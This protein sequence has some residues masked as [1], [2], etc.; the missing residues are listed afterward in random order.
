[1]RD[2]RRLAAE[3]PT[4]SSMSIRTLQQKAPKGLMQ[5]R[6]RPNRGGQ[7]GRRAAAPLRFQ[8]AEEE[9]KNRNREKKHLWGFISWSCAV[10]SSC[11]HKQLAR[12]FCFPALLIIIFCSLQCLNHWL[13]FTQS[14]HTV[15]FLFFFCSGIWSISVSRP[16]RSKA[17]A[18]SG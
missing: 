16:V 15:L 9:I 1:M 2:E 5:Q 13:S 6:R 11:P 7:A 17:A 10:K 4:Y 18:L 14:F 8:L 12:V 3:A